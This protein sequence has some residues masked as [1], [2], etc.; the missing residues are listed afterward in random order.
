MVTEHHV[1]YR[2]TLTS[3]L[4][5]I[6]PQGNEIGEKKQLSFG[7]GSPSFGFV[8]PRAEADMHMV[9]GRAEGDL[10]GLRFR[11]CVSDSVHVTVTTS[12]RCSP[13]LSRLQRYELH[14]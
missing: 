14:S 11:L 9:V 1:T 5:T 2:N 12:L 6:R 10:L 7:A 4:G 8:P 3:R 13:I